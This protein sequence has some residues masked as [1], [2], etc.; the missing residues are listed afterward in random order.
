MWSWIK[1][2]F[3][4]FFPSA[5]LDKIYGVFFPLMAPNVHYNVKQQTMK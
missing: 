5:V 2:M 1:I 4:F 3:G